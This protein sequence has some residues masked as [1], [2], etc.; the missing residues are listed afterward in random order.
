MNKPSAPIEAQIETNRANWDERADMHARDET[1]YYRIA[2]LI[3]GENLLGP[4]EKAELP[5][6]AGKRVAHF[7][8]HIG[9][10]TLSLMRQGASEAVGL[11]FSGHAIAHARR[12]AT[13]IG[14]NARF[15]QGSL[16][17]APQVIGNGFDLVY[18]SWGTIV[19]IADLPA[20]ARAIAACLKPGGLLYY[21]D[22]H[23]YAW[24]FAADG[25]GGAVIAKDYETP[26]NGARA[27]TVGANYSFA[28]Q[29]L[30]AADTF[31]WSH[32]LARIL[33]SL[34]DAGL[35]IERI[36]EHDALP[37]LPFD[38][39][40]QRADGL[41]RLADGFPKVPLA[42]SILARKVG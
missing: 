21:L 32:S 9:T 14:L 10:D 40:E 24:T 26:P 6:L 28:P 15:E 5:D 42:L 3:A 29:K 17:E 39:A 35:V 11:D 13:R 22:Q 36:G 38:G 4:I 20:W 37:W 1:G 31:Q 34:A 18:T 7:Q 41:W 19:W 33:N 8:C 25:R 2:G 30:A 12:L 16:Y 27:V 23:P